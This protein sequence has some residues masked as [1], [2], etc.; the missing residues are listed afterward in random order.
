MVEELK[1]MN[2]NQIIVPSDEEIQQN[3]E[4][5]SSRHRTADG[6][7]RD[8]EV[9]SNKIEANGKLLIYGII[10]DVTER[11]RLESLADGIIVT[12]TQGT[13]TSISP[14]ALIL[15]EAKD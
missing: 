6:S 15:F 12:D 8:V 11:K 7:L 14:M 1:K 9:Y 3:I 5:A 2:I 10:I 13:I 4:N